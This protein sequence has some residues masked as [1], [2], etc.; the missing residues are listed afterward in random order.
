MSVYKNT[1]WSF[2]S[3]IGTQLIN[4]LTN[5]VLARLLAPEYF[6]IL[7]MAMVFA[8]VIF[9]IQESGFSSI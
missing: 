1:L 9:V 7:G 8:G 4:V 6:G 5:M 2:L 3:I